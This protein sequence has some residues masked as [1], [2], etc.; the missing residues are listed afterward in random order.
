VYTVMNDSY[1]SIVTH[2]CVCFL[3]I[4]RIFIPKTENEIAVFKRKNQEMKQPSNTDNQR[5]MLKSRIFIKMTLRIHQIPGIV[6][7]PRASFSRHPQH[8]PA[9]SV[10]RY[11]ACS[12]LF[13]A[14][15]IEH[16]PLSMRL[17]PLSMRLDPLM[18]SRTYRFVTRNSDKNQKKFLLHNHIS[19]KSPNLLII[20]LNLHFSKNHNFFKVNMH[21]GLEGEGAS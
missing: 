12:K 15:S 16:E 7:S 17:E 11:R 13:A 21:E 2:T 1:H 20:S 14:P 6:F 19:L 9:P 5:M 4:S 10:Y 3:V 8:I 18:Q